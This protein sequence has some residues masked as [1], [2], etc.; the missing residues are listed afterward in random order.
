MIN[1]AKE[2]GNLCQSFPPF[3]IVH[4]YFPLK[5]C[6]FCKEHSLVYMTCDHEFT[7]PTFSY[8]KSGVINLHGF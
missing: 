2:G 5:W 3:R 4:V 1:Y 8:I 6:T 7:K